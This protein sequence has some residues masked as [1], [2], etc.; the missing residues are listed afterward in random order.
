MEMYEPYSTIRASEILTEFTVQLGGIAAYTGKA[1]ITNI[2]DTGRATIACVA[3]IDGWRNVVHDPCGPDQI[4]IESRAFIQNWS[5]S[6]RIR[7]EYRLIITELRAFLSGVSRWTEQVNLFLTPPWDGNGLRADYFYEMAAPIIG[8]MKSFFDDLEGEASQVP[9]ELT[10]AHRSYAQAEL[11]PLLMRAPFVFRTFTKP[12]G[13]AGDYQMVNQI[14]DDPRQGPGTYFHIVNAAFLQTAVA[15]AHR[16]RIEHLVG[17]LTRMADAAR[18]SGRTMH[19]LNVGCGPAIEVQQFMRTYPNPE[20]LSFELV[21]FN[22][23]TLAWTCDKLKS[24]ASETGKPLQFHL[25][26]DSVHTMLRRCIEAKPTVP[27]FDA[28]YCA[29]LFDYL[30]DRAC[31]RLMSHFADRTRPQGRLLVT[32]VHPSN[33]ERYSMEHIL[34]WYLIYRDEAKMAAIMPSRCSRPRLYTDATGVNVFAEA[35]VAEA[36]HAPTSAANLANP[37]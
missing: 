19:V 31:T 11:H 36:S 27:T 34:E 3:L 17:F 13:Y 6:Y 4:G 14:I 23:E 21:D 28:V 37:A 16:N 8:K 22:K 7:R 15:N 25:T 9:E 10:T 26:H 24:I 35:T 32:N 30:S 20:L 1:V 2:A 5:E 33:P 29:G 18:R 12:L